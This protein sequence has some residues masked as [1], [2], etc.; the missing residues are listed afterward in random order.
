MSKSRS[1]FIVEADAQTQAMFLQRGWSRADSE[2]EADLVC[3]TG[4][5]DV[6]PLL[7]GER[8]RPETSIDLPRDLKEIKIFKSLSVNQPKVGICRG[9][10]FLNVMCGG[11]LYQHVDNHGIHGK[12]DVLDFISGEVFLAT[13]THHQMMDPSAEAFILAMARE[14]KNKFRERMHI[15][16]PG[17]EK[18][19]WNDVEACYY[20]HYNAL[21]YQ[22][23]PE[24]AKR[25]DPCQ[26]KFYEYIETYLF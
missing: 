14:A 17:G 26:E 22:P 20:E 10:Q 15:I 8:L 5:A 23:H 16:E 18:R 2:E 19:E 11:S 25:G 6:C 13:S 1:V 24:Y 3:F 7:Y 21:C 4:G 12:H 9:G